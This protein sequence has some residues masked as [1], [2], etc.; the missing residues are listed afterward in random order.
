[1]SGKKPKGVYLDPDLLESITF[2]SLRGSS[3]KVYLRFLRKRVVQKVSRGQARR[4][5]YEIMNNG[6]IEF[7]VRE[8]Q[9]RLNIASRTFQ[10]AIKELVEKGFIDVADYKLEINK[11]TKLYAISERWKKYGTGEFV[12]PKYPEY[13]LGRG[14]RPGNQLGR[15]SR[16]KL[17]NQ[18]VN[19]LE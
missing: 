8:A 12:Q 17:N 11:V 9:A 16:Q 14:F 19:K 2:N 6:E 1:M 7:P 18:N 5:Q 15:R 3:M 10:A 4:E 13:P